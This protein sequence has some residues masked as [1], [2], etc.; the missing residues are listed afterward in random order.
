MGSVVSLMGA[1]CLVTGA[2]ALWGFKVS[3]PN[4]CYNVRIRGHWDGVTALPLRSQ[5]AAGT[6][7]GMILALMS[8]DWGLG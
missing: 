1:M 2:M 7:R 8:P 6:R 5:V 4:R 3:G